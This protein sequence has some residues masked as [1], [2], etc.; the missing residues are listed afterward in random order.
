MTAS[1]PAPDSSS[2]AAPDWRSEATLVAQSDA[3]HIIE[4]EDQA[5]RQAGALSA[6]IKPLQGPRKPGPAFHWDPNP[7][8]RWQPAA[9]GGF[10]MPINDHCAVVVLIMVWFG[11]AVGELPPARGDLFENMHPPVKYGDWDWRLDDP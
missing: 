4:S 6:M 2:P 9:G 5:A 3:Q 7:H 1:I 8:Y 11:C 10:I